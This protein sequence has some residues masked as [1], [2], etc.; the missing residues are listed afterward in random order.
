MGDGI[1]NTDAGLT[2]AR[3]CKQITRLCA[4]RAVHDQLLS[5]T[6]AV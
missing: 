4:A 2:Y 3:G 5:L 6:A 1:G